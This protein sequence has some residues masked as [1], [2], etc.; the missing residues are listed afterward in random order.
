L[1]DSQLLY[2]VEN[3]AETRVPLESEPYFDAGI[4]QQIALLPFSAATS[5]R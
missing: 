3:E 1:I 2:K 5:G 4:W